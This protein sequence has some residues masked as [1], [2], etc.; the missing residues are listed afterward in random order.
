MNTIHKQRI[1]LWID[2]LK[3]G[4]YIQCSG[5]LRQKKGFWKYQYCCLGVACMVFN[6]SNP[7]NKVSNKEFDWCSVLPEK[8]SQWFGLHTMQTDLFDGRN[9]YIAEGSLLLALAND[10]L[11]WSFDKIADA[12]EETYLKDKT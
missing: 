6:Q 3:S 1:K 5:C 12:I 8:V 9:P 4:K 7:K 2:A 11:R 10:Q